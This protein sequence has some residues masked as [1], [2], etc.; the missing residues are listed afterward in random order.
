VEWASGASKNSGSPLGT[1]P[2]DLTGRQQEAKLAW[3]AANL[4]P[5]HPAHELKLDT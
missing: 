2:V 5:R 4:K 1:D 3:M